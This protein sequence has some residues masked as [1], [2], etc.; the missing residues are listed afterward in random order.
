MSAFATGVRAGSSAAERGRLALLISFALVVALLALAPR[1]LALATVPSSGEGEELARGTLSGPGGDADA[2]QAPSGDDTRIPGQYIVVLEDSVAHPGR[3]AETQTEQRDG[4]LELVYRSA[5]K[6]YS[7]QLSKDAVEALRLDPRVKYVV[8]DRRM[9]TFAQSEPT[10][11]KRTF[12]KTNPEPDIDQTDDVRIEV[13][14]AVIDSGIDFEHPDL[15]VVERTNCVPPSENLEEEYSTCVNGGGVDGNG[16]GTHVAG[17]IG[18][19]DNGSGVVGIAPGARLWAVRVANNAGKGDM[20]WVIAGIDWVT[21]HASQ[22]EVANISMGCK[23]GSLPAL[24]TALTTSAKAGVV[25]A[26]AAGNESTNVANVSPANSPDVI[27]VSALA[28]YDGRPGAEAEE[29]TCEE[30]GADDQLAPFSN[31]GT[32]VEVAAPGVCILSTWKGKSE[33]ILSG[34]SMASPLVAGAA[35]LLAAKS[36]PANL[37]DVQAIRS[38]IIKNGNKEWTDTSGD[39]VQEPLLD[40]GTIAT[41]VPTIPS[42]GKVSL[43]GRINPLGASTEYLFEYGTTTSYGTKI[44]ISAENIGSGTDYVLVSKTVEGLAAKTSYHYRVKAINSKGAFY[45]ADKTF[46]VTPPVAVTGTASVTSHSAIL[47]GTVNPSAAPTTYYFEYGPTASYGTKAP[48]PPENLGSGTATLEV[49]EQPKELKANTVFHFRVVAQS[50]AGTVFGSDET[51]TTNPPKWVAETLPQPA[52]STVYRLVHGVSCMSGAACM[53]VGSYRHVGLSADVPLVEFWNGKAWTTMSTPIPSGLEEGYKYGRNA[54]LEDVSCPSASACMAIGHYKDTEEVVK[55]LAMSWNGSEWIRVSISPPAGS[56]ETKLVGIS[57][58][59]STACTAVGYSKDGSGVEK[60]L[61]MRWNGSAWVSQTTPVPAGA[62]ASTLQGVS[63]STSSSCVAVGQFRTSSGGF[64]DDLV[65]AWNGSTWAIQSTPNPAGTLSASLYDVSCTA[66]N[67]CTAVGYILPSGATYSKALGLRWDGSEWKVNYFFGGLGGI[68]L[69]GVSCTTASACTAGGVTWGFGVSE[70]AYIANWQGG[71]YWAADEPAPQSVLAGWWHDETVEALSCSATS[72]CI[73]VGGSHAGPPNGL[74][75]EVAFAE[76]MAQAPPKITAEAAAGITTREAT[77]KAAV[78]QSEWPAKYHFEYG[79]TTAYGKSAPVT[80]KEIGAGVSTVNLS[81]PISGLEPNTTYHFRLVASSLDVSAYGED[82]TFTTLN[83]APTYASSFG[84]KGAGNGQFGEFAAGIATDGAGNTWVADRGNHRVQK[85]NASGEYVS[86][87][88][89]FGA[90]NGQFSAPVDVARDGAGNIWVADFNNSR[91]QKFN[92]SGAYLSQ[93]GS[94][95]TGNGQFKT[96]SGVAVDPAGNIWV[97]DLGNSRIQ[98][99]N[100]S[101]EFVKAVGSA[102]SGNGQ[103]SYPQ[104]IETD[105]VGNVWVA[106]T[107]NHRI[108]KFDSNGEY[109]SQF[110]AKGTGNGQFESPRSVDVDPAGNVWVTDGNNRVQRFNSEGEYVA[111]FGVK[112]SGAGQFNFNLFAGVVADA[113]GNLW[114]VDGGNSRVQKW[115][116]STYVGNTGSFGAKGAGNGQFGEFAAGIATDGAGNTWVAD[117]GNHRVQKFNA[118]G[119]Y[120]SQFGSFGAG[121]GQFSAPVDVARDGAGNIWVA[122]F[123]NSRVQKFN[124][125]GAYLSQFGSFGTGNGQFKTVSGVAVDP[126]GN[127]WVAD[128]GNSRIQKFNASGE[129]VKAVGSAGSGNGQFSYPQGIETDAVGNVWVADTNNHRIQKFDSNGEY[130]SQFG[131]KGTGNGQFES[132]RSVDVDPAGNVWVTDGNNRVQR[133]NSEGEYVAQ[134]GVKGS[135]AGQFNFNLFAGVVADAKGNLWVVDGG[136]SRVQK[137][138]V[139]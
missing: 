24:N 61:A 129:F 23:C 51:F 67:A 28:D 33:A 43:R 7:A 87:F 39:G 25:Y 105:A 32:M 117:R 138:F 40:V 102:G 101:G 20:S 119:E 112:G 96:V 34:T 103:F 109:L 66:A 104:G 124:A 3:L 41:E 81:E 127:I 79:L 9:G 85:F 14:V 46:S 58:T 52:E 44:P 108:Q 99:F 48:I 29:P 126:A 82:L 107:N 8:A 110:G 30:D 60:P 123:N 11:I 90:G 70:R 4:E 137:W 95:G 13:D 74:A 26:V 21:A 18:A 47:N 12:A 98:K 64:F 55:P 97:A 88:G 63:C 50:M 100:A 35:A 72:Y 118:S 116:I 49:S 27:T 114:V 69:Y 139:L 53:A 92:A 106:D 71:E 5:L 22:I 111:Q 59:S 75:F 37:T 6:G 62:V 80:D 91:V 78:S 128:L 57:C 133:F 115:T 56:T 84:A 135:G 113:K 132:P 38:K 130:L 73:G 17:T 89:S 45:G 83:P 76:R 136:N 68:S 131:A 31:Y 125:S 65:M 42:A 19:I 54:L 86:Q 36:N 120:V 16:H 1:A 2:A 93:F 94:F 134:F 121:N 77:L 10:G 15:N 122:D